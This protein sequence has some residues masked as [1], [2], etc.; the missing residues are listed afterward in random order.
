M[1]IVSWSPG[2]FA[3]HA[4]HYFFSC[5]IDSLRLSLCGYLQPGMYASVSL[6]SDPHDRLLEALPFI[7]T[8]ASNQCQ[9][10][11]RQTFDATG[12]QE[13]VPVV[14][15]LHARNG[16]AL[17]LQMVANIVHTESK[18]LAVLTGR[19][20]PSEL[21][22]LIHLKGSAS[23]SEAETMVPFEHDNGETESGS[24]SLQSLVQDRGGNRDDG[25]SESETND[26]L[27]TTS[28]R[29]Q[30][31]RAEEHWDSDGSSVRLGREWRRLRVGYS[32][33][34][35]M[36]S[37]LLDL[38]RERRTGR[39]TERQRC[40]LRGACIRLKAVGAFIRNEQDF[41]TKR[42]LAMWLRTKHQDMN[43]AAVR[44]LG[45]FC[46][47]GGWRGAAG[48]VVVV[49]QPVITAPPPP[50]PLI[51]QPLLPSWLRPGE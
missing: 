44:C 36:D 49:V 34:S 22:G 47:Q 21:A 5:L 31:Y 10:V 43:A 12:A 3:V 33:T 39:A 30:P 20:I 23:Q 29:L 32:D 27:P 18:T 37:N 4:A 14:L 28:Q 48:G 2:A 17:L 11:I 45:E 15:H 40:A 51:V 13:N 9:N 6:V 42:I 38:R 1:R 24:M 25:S 16:T 41:K 8:R 46:W 35:S 26:V 7:H 19:E 50:S